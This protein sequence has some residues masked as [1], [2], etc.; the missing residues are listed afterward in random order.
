MRQITLAAFEEGWLD[1]TITEVHLSEAKIIGKKEAHLDE[2]DPIPL[3][4]V[5][6]V[7]P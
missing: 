4:V 5:W 6:A 3:E 1:G 7:I 2:N